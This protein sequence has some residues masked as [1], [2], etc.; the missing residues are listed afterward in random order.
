M[1]VPETRVIKINKI[2]CNIH[3]PTNLWNLIYDLFAAATAA[4]AAAL[5]R[6]ATKSTQTKPIKLPNRTRS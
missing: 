6:L 4:S 2:E 3:S 5:R 1:I